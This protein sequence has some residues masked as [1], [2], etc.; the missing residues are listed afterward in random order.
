MTDVSP[1]IAL[2]GALRDL[3]SDLVDAEVHTG[4][5]PQ[6]VS[7][8]IV[9][10]ENYTD[11]YERTLGVV[12]KWGCR[13]YQIR[14]ISTNRA[15]AVQFKHDIDVGIWNAFESG[16]F[17]LSDGWACIGIESTNSIPTL[18]VPDTSGVVYTQCGIEYEFKI[19]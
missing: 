13:Y 8:P 19:Q 1:Q 2:E 17:T 10:I 15:Q 4:Y 7:Y 12:R 11:R 5:A 16:Q 9:L 6:D 18:T 3:C 14:C